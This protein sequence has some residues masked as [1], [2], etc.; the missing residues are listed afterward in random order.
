MFDTRFNRQ[1]TPSAV[2]IFYIAILGILA[3]SNF[4]VIWEIILQFRGEERPLVA[5]AL[6]AAAIVATALVALLLRFWCESIVIKFRVSET[7]AEIRDSLRASESSDPE[8]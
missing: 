1:I 5:L 8:S 6:I 4:A 7:L 3:L 2:R